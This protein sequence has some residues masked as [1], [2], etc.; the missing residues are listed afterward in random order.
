MDPRSILA[1]PWGRFF[2]GLYKKALDADILSQSAQ[3]AFYFS[4]SIFPLLFFLV[5][6]FGL[7]V[8]STD[9]LQK[10]MEAYLRQIMPWAAFELVRNTM[11]EIIERSS[12]GKL[13]FGLVLTLWTASAG[14]DSLRTALNYIYGFAETRSWWKRKTQSLLLTL[15]FILLLA[16]GLAIV[17]YG[18]QMIQMG[19]AAIGMQVESHLFLAT[20]Q[21]VS[22]LMVMLLM[23]ETIYDLLPAFPK[24]VRRW[25]TPGAIAAI[26]LWLLLTRGFAVYLLYFNSYSRTYGSLG[27]VM[28]LLLWLYLTAAVLIVGGAINS[29]YYS[30]TDAPDA[31]EDLVESGTN[32]AEEPA[33]D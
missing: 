2:N 12:T 11:R 33:S 29:V 1:F 3:V 25:I 19:M 15:V 13:T 20:I 17:F 31:D 7:V 9:G 30:V 10:E 4:F 23:L 21:W 8:D 26:V 27:A 24:K 28:I 22:I 6:L 14:V 18:W 32:A 5:S 16:I